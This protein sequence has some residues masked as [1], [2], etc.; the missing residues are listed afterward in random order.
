MA[1]L[2]SRAGTKLIKVGALR[3]CQGDSAGA[4]FT[5]SDAS[6][7]ILLHLPSKRCQ[8]CFQMDGINTRKYRH[9][10][11]TMEFFRIYPCFFYIYISFSSC[12]STLVLLHLQNFL[13]VFLYFLKNSFDCFCRFKNI[14]S[15]VGCSAGPRGPQHRILPRLQLSFLGDCRD[16]RGTSIQSAEFSLPDQ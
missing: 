9:T 14:W 13:F 3:C 4:S 10:N 6:Q 8:T 11:L 1:T 7:P 2:K 15:Q 16:D 5:A 12:K